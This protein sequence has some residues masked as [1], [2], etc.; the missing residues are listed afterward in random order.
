MS[1][2]VEIPKPAGKMD[3]PKPE[4]EVVAKP[5]RRSF[6]AA[7]KRRIVEEALSCEYGEVAGLLRRE[8]LYSSQLAK[9]R[10][11]YE[12][13]GN[14]GLASKQRGRKPKDPQLKEMEKLRQ[15]NERL[16]KKLNQAELIIEVQKKVS[17][18]FE[19]NSTEED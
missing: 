7:Y 3:D 9:W 16:Q 5:K 19:L 8:G 18:L 11:Q 4:I 15:Q 14:K 13:G 2:A 1:A 12:A 17:A 6:T 10:K